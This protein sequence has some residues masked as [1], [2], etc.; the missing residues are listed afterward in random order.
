[1][2]ILLKFKKGNES[3]QLSVGDFGEEHNWGDWEEGGEKPPIIG[4]SADNAG[5][6]AE[7]EVG[8]E[9]EEQEAEEYWCEA[10]RQLNTNENE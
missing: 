1:M 5:G 6:K 10:V 4:K 7:D 8:A 3:V 9:I 2:F